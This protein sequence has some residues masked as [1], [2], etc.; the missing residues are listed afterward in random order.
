MSKKAG[1]NLVYQNGSPSTYLHNGTGTK[2]YGDG[3]GAGTVVGA[4]IAGALPLS[5]CL[6]LVL[7]SWSVF[8]SAKFCPG[9]IRIKGNGKEAAYAS[10]LSWDKA[11]RAKEQSSRLSMW[12]ETRTFQALTERTTIQYSRIASWPG[13]ALVCVGSKRSSS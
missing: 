11:Q 13:S 12:C 7:T 10:D 3:A 1:M 2:A 9:T 5:L 8:V 6:A 4:D